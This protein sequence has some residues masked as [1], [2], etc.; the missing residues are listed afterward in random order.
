[1]TLRD[2]EGK[3]DGTTG[4]SRSKDNKDSHTE[5]QVHYHQEIYYL[6]QVILVSPKGPGH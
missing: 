2:I 4:A 1:M 3:V 5:K 6:K